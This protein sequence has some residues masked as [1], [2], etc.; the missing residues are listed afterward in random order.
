MEVNAE[1]LRDNVEL[2]NV[3]VVFPQF[4]LAIKNNKHFTEEEKKQFLKLSRKFQ[5]KLNS[6]TCERIFKDELR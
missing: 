1:W 3:N 4:N 5:G 2:G 6:I